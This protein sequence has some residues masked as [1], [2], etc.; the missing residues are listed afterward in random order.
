M[1]ISSLLGEIGFGEPGVYVIY[2][3]AGAGKTTL[4]YCIMKERQGPKL[5]IASEPNVFYG[6]LKLFAELGRA[7]YVKDLAEAFLALFTWARDSKSGVAVVD[8]VSAFAQHEAA[9]QMLMEKR[10]PKP[11]E[12][13]APLSFA[14]NAMS[15][16]VVDAAVQNGHTL[17]FIAQERP[18]IGRLWRGEDAAPS[19][20]MRSLHSVYAVYRLVVAADKTRVLRAVLHRKSEYEGKQVSLPP[21]C[22]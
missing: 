17:L 8:S 22:L 21:P 7:E 16:A 1:S 18:A 11:L 13:V 9:R 20:A 12:V 5:Y 15:A 19:F 6:Q 14:A 4:A 3:A 10:T 2:G